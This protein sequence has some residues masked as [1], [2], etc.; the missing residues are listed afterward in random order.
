MDDT[1]I[2]ESRL[3]PIRSHQ[4]N[5]GILFFSDLEIPSSL[6]KVKSRLIYSRNPKKG[7]FRGI[8]TQIGKQGEAKFVFCAKGSILD[9]SVDLRT[10][11]E[12]YLVSQSIH[13]ESESGILF[14]P[15]GIGHGFQTLEDETE[16][17][18]LVL[19]ESS[20]ENYRRWNYQSKDFQFNLPLEISQISFDDQNAPFFNS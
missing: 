1:K 13:L 3:I 17:T 16:V 14:L 7:T 11:S 10:S 4:D 5:R 8:H 12:S 9:F 18:Y 19:G 6:L 20:I 2:H 15:S